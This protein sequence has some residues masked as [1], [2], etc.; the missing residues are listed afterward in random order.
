MMQ[1]VLGMHITLRRKVKV[2]VMGIIENNTVLNAMPVGFDNRISRKALVGICGLS[3]RQVRRAIEDIVES[4]QAIIINMH[5][6][7]FIPDLEDKADRDYYRLFILHVPKRL[8]R[9]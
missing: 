9:Y 8:G 6:G 3:D 5:K 1:Y 4:R 7:Y 2:M